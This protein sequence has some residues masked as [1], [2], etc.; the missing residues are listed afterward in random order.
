MGLPRGRMPPGNREGP[1]PAARGPA[2]GARSHPQRTAVRRADPAGDRRP[3]APAPAGPPRQRGTPRAQGNRR[4]RRRLIAQAP[5][6]RP[7]GRAPRLVSPAR[8]RFAIPATPDGDGSNFHGDYYLG[9][10]D[11]SSESTFTLNRLTPTM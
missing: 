7:A 9:R 2:D 5:R 6:S 3:V 11:L 4:R 8:R 1:A 10:N